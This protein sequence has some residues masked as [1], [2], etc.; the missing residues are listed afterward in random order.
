LVTVRVRLV[1]ERVTGRTEVV[2]RRRGDVR[3]WRDVRDD[4]GD[5]WGDHGL[6]H[7][8]GLCDDGHGGG[9][10]GGGAADRLTDD[11]GGESVDGVGLVPDRAQETV[12]VHGAVVT[13]HV[14]A[15]SRFLLILLVTG[16]RIVDRV[17]ELVLGGS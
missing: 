9:G 3:D 4:G 1:V 12:R 11:F 8:G 16:G 17:A 5:S 14:V 15:V 13:G 2:R 6:D 10:G 7:G